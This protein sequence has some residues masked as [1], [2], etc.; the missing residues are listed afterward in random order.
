MSIELTSDTWVYGTVARTYVGTIERESR[1]GFDALLADFERAAEER[2]AT[3]I[4]SMQLDVYPDDGS[5]ARWVG[6]GVAAVLERASW[7]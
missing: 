7:Y 5:G 1:E 3:H 6:K 2:G 4:V